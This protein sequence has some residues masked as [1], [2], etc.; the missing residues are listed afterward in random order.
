MQGGWL[1]R[2]EEHGAGHKRVTVPADF[3]VGDTA[4]E[5]ELGR[6]EDGLIGVASVKGLL[7]TTE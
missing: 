6:K 1:G 2:R 5:L 4:T 3:I 7:E